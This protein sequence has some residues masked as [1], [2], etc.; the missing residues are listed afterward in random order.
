M[1]SAHKNQ[2]AVLCCQCRNR[3]YIKCNYVS[4]AEY[5]SLRAT[6]KWTCTPCTIQRHSQIFPFTP[7]TDDVLLRANVTDLP[8]IVDLLP[9]LQIPSKLQNLP[10]LSDYDIDENIEPD[11]DCNYYNFQEFQSS[12]TH[13]CQVS[14]NKMLEI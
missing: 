3:I 5:E 9:S 11:I 13:S 1:K 4:P 12:E 8:S 10:N 2:K 14:E 6:T 7:E